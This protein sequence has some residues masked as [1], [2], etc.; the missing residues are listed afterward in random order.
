MQFHF[1]QKRED[2]LLSLP[3][4][5]YVSV[6]DVLCSDPGSA[7]FEQLCENIGIPHDQRRSWLSVMRFSDNDYP[8]SIEERL[9]EIKA[10]AENLQGWYYW[11]C[12]P[13]CLPDS[14]PIGPFETENEAIADARSYNEE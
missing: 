8:S 10:E 7:T 5:F 12:F 4:A 14:D 2:N 1:D 9:G 3:D 11:A 6:D 13:G